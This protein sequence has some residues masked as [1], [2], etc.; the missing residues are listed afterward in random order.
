M[1]CRHCRN[2]G[3]IAFADLANAPA[4]NSMLR[5]EAL[6]EPEVYYPLV[7]EV[8]D[9]CF[10]AQVEEVKPATD[11]FD[12]DYTYFSSYSRSW[13]A[14]AE[15]FAEAATDRFGLGSDSQVIEVASND[16][17]LLQYFRERGIPTLG[18]E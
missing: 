2:E 17:Y 3:F 5:R 13:L 4:S 1:K 10:L 8:C 14:H 18:I 9:N 12:S 7:V 15:A 11:I 16:G 6:G